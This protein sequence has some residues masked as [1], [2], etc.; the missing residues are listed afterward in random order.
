MIVLG[1]DVPFHT[2]I[3]PSYFRRAI[4]VTGATYDK[5]PYTTDKWFVLQGSWGPDEIMDKAIASYTPN[6]AWIKYDTDVD[7]DMN[8]GGTSSSTPQIAAACA[9]WLDRTVGN[10]HRIGDAFKPVDTH[11]LTERTRALTRTLE[12]LILTLGMAF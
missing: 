6:V 2:T 10:S 1:G 3:W 11:Y 7:Y 8:G 5:R 4:T 12:E 9:L